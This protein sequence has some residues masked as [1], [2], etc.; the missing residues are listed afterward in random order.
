MIET[1]LVEKKEIVDGLEIKYMFKPATLDVEHLIIIFS[2]YGGSSLFTYDFAGDSLKDIPS[3]ILWIKD[4]F[5]GAPCYYLCKHRDFSIEEKVIKFIDKKINELS[6]CKDD[7][8]ILGASKGGSAALYFGIKYHFKNV[9]SSAPQFDLG[10]FLVSPSHFESCQ[11]MFDETKQDNLEFFNNLLYSEI[12]KKSKGNE[13]IYLIYSECDEEQDYNKAIDLLKNSFKNLSLVNVESKLVGTHNRITGYSVPLIKSILLQNAFKFSPDIDSL[14]IGLSETPLITD[15]LRESQQNLESYL[16]GFTYSPKALQLKIVNVRRFNNDDNVKTKY[17]LCLDSNTGVSYKFELKN[18]VVSGV[19]KQDLEKKYYL[20]S[21]SKMDNNYFELVKPLD[22][23]SIELLQYNLSVLQV[24]E[25]KELKSMLY[26]TNT[27]DVLLNKD[28]A[29]LGKIFSYRDNSIKLYVSPDISSYEP[30]IFKITKRI[31]DKSKFLYEGLF[32]KYGLICDDYS[33]LDYYMVFRNKVNNQSTRI[34][35]GKSNNQKL[36]SLFSG[37]CFISKSAFTSIACKIL[38]L[39]KDV[40]L[41]NGEYEI[42]IS[43]ISLSHVFSHKFAY[44]KVENNVIVSESLY[45]EINNL[46]TIPNLDKQSINEL[47]L[48]SEQ[49][50]NLAILDYIKNIQIPINFLKYMKIRQYLVTTK[51]YT[52]LDYLQYSFQQLLKDDLYEELKEELK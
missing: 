5:G 48:M 23:N 19:T 28:N 12:S 14:K 50:V 7:V 3:N 33:D 8:T 37:E 15:T 39:G 36:K 30:D 51:N 29:L 42:F 35:V 6:L 38:E 34:R 10:S 47:V 25:G 13:S 46:V 21:Y 40:K 1:K 49:T 31:I 32:I 43:M 41:V 17:Y 45:S 4:E 22:L 2:G 16:E 24:N 44:W 52:L 20:Y 9:I 11:E 27:I 18:L 26:S